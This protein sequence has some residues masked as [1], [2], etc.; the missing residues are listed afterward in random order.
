MAHAVIDGVIDIPRTREY[1]FDE[2]DAKLSAD[3]VSVVF[4]P[5]CCVM[6]GVGEGGW[7]MGEGRE[8]REEGRERKGS[9][10]WARG[11]RKEGFAN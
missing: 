6:R 5:L 3:A 10:I 11:K 7:K 2:E 1:K 9:C 8:G 4:F